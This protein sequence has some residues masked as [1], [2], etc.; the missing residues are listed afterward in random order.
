MYSFD[1]E[2]IILLDKS[3][4]I[5]SFQAVYRLKKILKIKKIGHSGTL[6][7]NATGLLI[8]AIG[9]A[10]KLLKHIIG[11]PKKYIAEFYFGIQT[12]TDDVLGTVIKKYKGKIDLEKIK[13]FLPEFTGKIKQIPPNFSAVHVNGKRAYKIA[14]GGEK[15]DI[16]AKEIEIKNINLISFIS[17]ILKLEIECSSGTYIRSIARDIG[18]KTEY[19]AHLCS[20]RRL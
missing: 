15:P 20:L 13:K 16:K 1:N 5:T 11:Q 2:G 8:I 7:S 10:T 17:P 14:I 9:K 12:N 18:I 3:S 4:G 19:Y 6:D